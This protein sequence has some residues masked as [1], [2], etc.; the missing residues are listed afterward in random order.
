MSSSIVPDTLRHKRVAIVY[1]WL[2][3]MRGAERIVEA[4]CGM[5][6]DAVIFTNVYQPAHI[7]PAIRRHEVRT[8]FINRLPWPRR[9]LKYY[10]PLMPTALALLDLS[11]FDLVIS[12]ES[13][14]SKGVRT[15]E[16]ATH[17]CICCSPMRYIWGM[18]QDYADTMGP[19]ERLLFSIAAR[20][21]RAWDQASA[22]RVD[23][24]VS[25]SGE[26]ARRV[27]EVYDR[28]APILYPPVDCERFQPA[29]IREDFYLVVGK[30]I[31]YKQPQLAVEACNQTGRRL[32]VLGEGEL[33]EKLRFMA[34]PTVSMMGWQPDS[35]VADHYGRCKAL[36]FPGEEDFGIVPVEAMASGAPVIALRRGGALDSVVEG[37]TGLFF[38]EPSVSSL[39]DALDRFEAAQAGFDSAGICAH[40][41]NFDRQVFETEMASLLARIVPAQVTRS[42][43]AAL[44]PQDVL[45]AKPSDNI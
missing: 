14:P 28:D 1:H 40:A 9:F 41:R 33:L 38:D 45:L 35:V 21:M 24:M 22:R 34:G 5:F 7:S 18:Q 27:R 13:G 39:I 11:E 16:G 23:H 12:I 19:L 36:I 8:S 26:S 25:I 42:V 43:R 20:Y 37:E 4:L 29:P 2:F 3:E 15:A 6:P 44:V 32:V 31:P 17:L 30:L 10:L